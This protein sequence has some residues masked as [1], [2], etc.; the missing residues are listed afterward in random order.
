LRL[1][2]QIYEGHLIY[3][4]KHPLHHDRS[5]EPRH[6]ELCRQEFPISVKRMP[7]NS[8]AE[9]S[10]KRSQVMRTLHQ[11][12]KIL[13]NKGDDHVKND[14]QRAIPILVAAYALAGAM[15]T[16]LMAEVPTPSAKPNIILFLVDDMG[17][18]DTSV[19]FL[20]DEEGKAVT[21]DLNTYYRTPAMQRLADQGMSFTR[22]YA[23]SVCSPTRASILTGQ[24]SARH[25]VTQWIN[26][27]KKN[28]G[29]SD[30]RWEG[31]TSKDVTL[32]GLLRS[33]GYKTIFCGKGHFAPLGKEGENPEKLGFDVNIAGC[34][35][36]RPAS[37]YGTTGF[38]KDSNRAI[39]G[40]SQH[41]GK[42]IFLTEAL[43]LEVNKEIAIA[44]KEEKPFF[45][46]MS[47]YAVHAP[48]N[49]DA[50]FADNYTD[51]GKPKNAQAYATLIEGMDKSLNDIMNLLE[52]LGVA[53]NTI[54]MFIGDNGG[55]APLGPTHGYASSAPLRGKKGTHYEGGMRVPCITAWAK[56]ADNEMQKKFPILQGVVHDEFATVC[57]IFP[58]M[59]G[60]AGVNMPKN[61]V[62]DGED[63][64]KFLTGHKGFHNQKFLMHF[65]HSHRSSWF[66]TYYN[67]SVKLTYHY[68]KTGEERYELFDLEK[69]PYEKQNLTTASPDL[70]ARMLKE[71]QTELIQAD[72]LYPTDKGSGKAQRPE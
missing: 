65:P 24:Y 14:N 23:N 25:R 8:T 63:I 29:P 69:D 20:T 71:M 59:L 58:T 26:P 66:S 3:Q 38:G 28:E 33:S 57:D 72:A 67:S 35:F 47:H 4:K 19:P 30:W 5:A 45:T 48:F 44:V 15:C 6:D 51:S 27:S 49:S 62:V 34:A 61:H 2:S 70:L 41:H 32:P 7:R 22:F 68:T 42:D 16:P 11:P 39:P 9:F 10:A 64:S 56:R 37:Y 18:M 13:S 31:L 46:Y 21:H 17:V 43:T 40:L 53:E 1:N 12:D 50:R 55:D 52:A 36:G 60:W 54:I